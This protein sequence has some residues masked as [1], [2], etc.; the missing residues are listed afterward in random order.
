M[1]AS[2]FR[3]AATEKALADLAI[4]Q[5]FLEWRGQ[6]VNLRPSGYERYGR[7]VKVSC[8]T[9]ISPLLTDVSVQTGTPRWSPWFAAVLVHVWY[10][11]G[12]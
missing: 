2:Q 7:V 12:S 9:G 10:M 6:D 11:E 3:A 5:G 1:T 4:Y 8:F